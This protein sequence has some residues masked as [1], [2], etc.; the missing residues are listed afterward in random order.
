MDCCK[1]S[2]NDKGSG[3]SS[4]S[5]CHSMSDCHA[6]EEADCHGT[7]KTDCHGDAAEAAGGHVCPETANKGTKSTPVASSAAGLLGSMSPGQ[8]LVAEA[9]LA[10]G[11]LVFLPFMLKRVGPKT[12]NLIKKSLD[13]SE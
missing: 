6:M 13:V 3:S 4:K 10:A 8:R 5:D 11:I 2:K 1:K 7:G 12:A 9:V